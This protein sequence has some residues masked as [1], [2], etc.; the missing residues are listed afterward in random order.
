MK[1]EIISRLAG[2]RAT[3]LLF[4]HGA[5]HGAWCWDVHFLEFFTRNGYDAHALSL[6]GHGESEGREKLR[7]TRI[8]DYVDDVASVAQR[9]RTPPVVIGHS[10]GGFVVQKYLEDHP[11]PAGVLLASVPAQGV[12]RTALRLG[13]RHPLIFAKSNL[14]F[15]LYPLVAT[16][17]LAREAFFSPELDDASLRSYWSKLQDE[18]FRG[19]LDMLALD[20]PRPARVR[21]PLLVL[22]GA[23]DSIFYPWQ[24]DA[25]ARAYNTHAEHLP[26][27]AH[28]MMLEPRWRDAADRI[29]GWLGPTLNA[30]RSVK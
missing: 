18:S 8:K 29:L 10:M 26:G 17:E 4:V 25:T 11:A 19:F 24:I 12:L 14:T 21:T 13:A 30:G 3:P 6:R 16:P 28:D 22:G 7:W 20:L 23:K 15:S 5:W 27:L 2:G 1:L 9:F